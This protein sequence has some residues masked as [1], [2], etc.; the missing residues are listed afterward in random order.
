LVT[1]H[2]VLNAYGWIGLTVLGTLVLLWPTV[3]HARMP[4]TADAAARRALPLLVAGLLIAAAGPFAGM[5]LLVTLGMIVWLVGATLLAVEG[6]REARAM[7]PGTF[8]G[9]SLMA[10]FGWVLFAA[11]ALGVQAAVAPD[12]AIL[13]GEYLMMLGPLVAGFGVQIVSGAL[14]YLLPVVALGSPAAAKAGAEMLDRGAV[15]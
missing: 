12:W 8:A 14:S 2:I 4:A 6:W 3:L 10:A 15:V 1:S 11:V 13:R 9:W 7:P 5:R